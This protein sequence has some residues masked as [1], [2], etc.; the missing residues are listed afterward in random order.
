MLDQHAAFRQ[1]LHLAARFFHKVNKHRNQMPAAAG[2]PAE[3]EHILQHVSLAFE[4]I[5]ED[6]HESV[7]TLLMHPT[8]DKSLREQVI[9]VA[10]NAAGGG[11]GEIERVTNQLT[12]LHILSHLSHHVPY[13]YRVDNRVIRGSRPTPD[14]LNKLNAGGCG[15]TVNLCKEMNNGDADLIDAAGLTGMMQTLHI[16]VTDNTPPDHDQVDELITYLENSGGRVYV[17]CEA[18]VG[19]TGVMVACY[20]MFQGWPLADALCEAKQFGCSMPDQLAFIENRASALRSA[21]PSQDDQ[22]TEEK[23]RETALMNKDPVGLDR[24]LASSS[25]GPDP[26]AT[27]QPGAIP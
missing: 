24:A 13:T 9:D 14:K 21:R 2:G 5:P 22:P 10:V 23:L 25:I 16:K 6:M 26:I 12:C 8:E 20:R 4:D 7:R 17:H 27:G 3:N 18:G 11:Y 19:R 1:E 15:A